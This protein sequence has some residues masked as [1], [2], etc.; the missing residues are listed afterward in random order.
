MVR[1]RE[2]EDSEPRPVKTACIGGQGAALVTYVCRRGLLGRQAYRVSVYSVLKVKCIQS[3][4]LACR[5][6]NWSSAAVAV[7]FSTLFREDFFSTRKKQW[8][9]EVPEAAVSPE[10][11]SRRW[12]STRLVDKNIS[13]F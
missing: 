10:V 5:P 8:D 9:K 7:T 6:I 4:I 3:M 11:K 1:L 13:E 12:P 2:E